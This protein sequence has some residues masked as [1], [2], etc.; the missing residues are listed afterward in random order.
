MPTCGWLVF[1]QDNATIV[2]LGDPSQAGLVHFR[3]E[4]L[5]GFTPEHFPAGYNPAVVTPVVPAF[6]FLR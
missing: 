4:E 6:L 3:L 5:A 1:P 2:W